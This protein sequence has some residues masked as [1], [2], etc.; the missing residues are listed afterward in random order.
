MQFARSTMRLAASPRHALRRGF[1]LIELLVVMAIIAILMALL[2]PAVQ[3][4]R[5]AARRSQCLN[6][7]RQINIAAA[8]YLSSHG[9]Y[10]S[11]WISSS[12]S[13]QAP[14]P[15]HYWT[16]SGEMKFKLSDK[17]QFAN[18]GI[19]PWA[20]SD[21]WGWHALMLSQMDATTMGID[22]RR[23]KGGA[24]NS[25]ALQATISSYV[26]PS[27]SQQNGGLAYTNYRGNMGTN[28][29]NGVMYMNSSVSDRT[30]KDGTGTTIMF[31]ETNFG[32]WGDAM[33]C[34]ARVPTNSD[35][36]PALDWVIFSGTDNA[37]NPLP[38]TTSC[39]TPLKCE[40]IQTLEKRDSSSYLIFSFG[41]QHPDIVTFAM[42]DGSAR[43]INKQ[44]NLQILQSLAT[45][46]GN[47]RIG[48]D[49]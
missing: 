25:P 15:T 34:C 47:E 12:G 28:Y 41:S 39:P 20:I 13:T 2:L 31:G 6:N 33:S 43:P 23:P 1:T 36:R 21:E 4:A 49:Y 22:Y 45:R 3:M 24:P 44:I 11:G 46:D 29:N 38:Y 27:A 7:I 14:S 9:S 48:D 17:S 26:C 37:G 42:A 32:F 16:N 10:P 18:A 19:E 35:N 40:Q 30:I 5:E 8:N